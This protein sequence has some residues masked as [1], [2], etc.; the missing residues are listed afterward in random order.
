LELIIADIFEIQAA[1]MTVVT[2]GFAPAETDATEQI[3]RM[4]AAHGCDPATVKSVEERKIEQPE[5][6]HI[7]PPLATTV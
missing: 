1:G 4:G 5:A 6:D 3:Q 7:S 2:T